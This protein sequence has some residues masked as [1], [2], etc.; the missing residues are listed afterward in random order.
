MNDFRLQETEI[1]EFIEFAEWYKNWYNETAS[2]KEVL[3][4][5]LKVMELL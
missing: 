5:Y 4:I 3:T 2:I 1:R